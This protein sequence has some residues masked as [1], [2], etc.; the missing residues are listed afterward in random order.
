M[1]SLCN[2]GN[3]LTVL[4]ECSRR[5]N[6]A[7][8][9]SSTYDSTSSEKCQHGMLLVN[10]GLRKSRVVQKQK[11]SDVV[12][13]RSVPGRIVPAAQSTVDVSP[14]ENFDVDQKTKEKIHCQRH[15]NID[16]FYLPELHF[17]FP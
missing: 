11:S 3:V 5:S 10:L 9:N 15:L 16:R 13:H 7:K 1:E 6:R 17:C 14:G 2:F 8:I 4:S 12:R